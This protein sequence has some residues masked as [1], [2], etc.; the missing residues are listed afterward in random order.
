MISLIVAMSPNHAIGYNGRLPWFLPEDLAN[1]KRLTTGH[2]IIMGRHTFDSLPHGALPQRRNIVLSKNEN[3]GINN[4][5]IEVYSSLEK[6]LEKCDS[7]E[8]TF[9]IGGAEIY[10]TALPKTS[11]LYITLV[12]KDPENADT[13]FPELDLKEWK[14][15]K[16]EKHEGFSLIEL[17]RI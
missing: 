4:L 15:E 17:T 3:Y 6:A 12:D 9:V 13:F 16:R 5:D 14:E 8:E 2:A 11:K 10:K 7:N 1:F